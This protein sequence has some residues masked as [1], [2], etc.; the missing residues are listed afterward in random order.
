MR[1]CLDPNIANFTLGEANSIRRVVAKK[2][3]DQVPVMKEKFLSSCKSKKLGEYVWHTTVLPQMSYSFSDIHASVYSM[4]GIQTLY[5][6]TQMP[7]IYWNTACLIVN[8][9][10]AELLEAED[11]LDEDDTEENETTTKKKNKNVNYGKISTAIG[12]IE[13][14]GIK[15]LPP[16]INNSDL[17]FKPDAKRNSII[18]GLKGITRIS[19]SLV[20]EIMN[21]RP[22]TGLEDFLSKVK[23]NKLQMINLIKAGTFDEI[24]AAPREIIM[25]DYLLSVADQKKRITL[26]NMQMLATKHLIPSELETEQKIF[27]FNKYIKNFKKGDCYELDSYAMNFFTQHYD[28]EILEEVNIQ[29]NESTGLIKQKIWDKTYKKEMDPIRDWMKAN[30]QEILQDLNN[31]LFKETWEKYASGSISAWEME[32][33]GFYYHE[34]ELAKL[35]KDV[36]NIVNF[37]NLPEEPVIERTVRTRTGDE[38]PLFEIVR[39]AGTVIDKDKNRGIV[40]LLTTTGVVNVKVWKNQFAAWDRQI[41]EKDENG[42]KKIKERSWFKRGTKLMVSGIRR[43]D[44]FVPKKYKGTP[45][46]LFEKI[47][48]MDDKGF[49]LD[50]STERINVE[51]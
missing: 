22:Y 46:S 47:N 30:Q 44:D 50:S 34:H 20:F 26:Q 17:I 24:C 39:I 6:A 23:V 9:G 36:Y 13:Q 10:G 4:V 21:N 43:G 41:S 45:F 28:E 18:Y 48:E 2:V 31:Q 40:T 32:S 3:V 15:C 11:S 49:I 25:K 35:K 12:E 33:L 27:F 37:F 38:I 51:E 19:T 29:G 7:P 16:D 42:V 8:A 1:V 5:L 14:R